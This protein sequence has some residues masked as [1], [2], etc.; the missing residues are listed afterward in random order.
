MTCGGGK[1]FTTAQHDSRV[2]STTHLL[3]TSVLRKQSHIDCT[4]KVDEAHRRHMGRRIGP[5][6]TK[7]RKGKKN[8][9]NHK[10]GDHLRLHDEEVVRLNIGVHDLARMQVVNYVENLHGEVHHQRLMHDSG[11]RLPDLVV[12]VQQRTVR[13]EFRN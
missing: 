3:K 9:R 4:T 7:G 13:R 6:N 11:G 10:S 5:A 1:S 2:I 12:D 8:E